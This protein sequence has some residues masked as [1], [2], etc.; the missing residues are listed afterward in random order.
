MYKTL[1]LWSYQ[2]LDIYSVFKNKNSGYAY[3]TDFIPPQD[4]NSKT[5]VSY[6]SLFIEAQMMEGS[7]ALCVTIFPTRTV[8]APE[9]M[10]SLTTIQIFSVIHVTY[11][12]R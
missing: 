2:I 9:T 6:S 1:S 3:N 12:I 4:A 8:P 10:W 7:T 5:P 11:V